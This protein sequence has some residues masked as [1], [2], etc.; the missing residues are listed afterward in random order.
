MP[1][2]STTCHL[3]SATAAS[4][5]IE[6]VFRI[7]GS[8]PKLL[9]T[10][11]GLIFGGGLGVKLFHHDMMDA[12]RPLARH[13]AGVG[14]DRKPLG[15]YYTPPALAEAALAYLP[16]PRARRVD[17]AGGERPVPA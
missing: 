15:A 6:K 2:T 8:I 13:S 12:G 9:E 7:I 10:R 16:R 5:F 14:R 17:L 1:A 3:R 4:V 11:Q